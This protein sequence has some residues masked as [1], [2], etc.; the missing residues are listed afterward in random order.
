LGSRVRLLGVVTQGAEDGAALLVVDGKP[1][2]PY[3]VGAPVVG[4]WRL[5]SVTPRKAQLRQNEQRIDLAMPP[6]AQPARES[7]AS[8]RL[9]AAP[10]AP[11][12]QQGDGASAPKPGVLA[13]AG[14]SA[15]P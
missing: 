2:R 15:A 10:A 3:R 5:A 12:A 7:A 14:A 9:N 13:P 1:P 6:L 8:A 11:V 4:H